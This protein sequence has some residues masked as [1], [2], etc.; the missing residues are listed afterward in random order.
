MAFLGLRITD[1]ELRIKEIAM[2]KKMSSKI[3]Y[4]ESVIRNP[5][6]VM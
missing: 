1:C 2:F 3:L 5:Q 4:K 6:S